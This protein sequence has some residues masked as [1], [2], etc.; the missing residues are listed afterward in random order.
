MLSCCFGHFDWNKENKAYSW[1]E[2]PTLSVRLATF[3]TSASWWSSTGVYMAASLPRSPG[4]FSVFWSFLTVQLFGWCLRVLRF[5]TL[6]I[7]LATDCLS[8]ESQW[9]QVLLLLLLLEFFTSALAD[10]FSLELSD[11]KSPQVSRTHLGCSQQCCHL[12]TLYLS[13]N[14]HVL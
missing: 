11:S 4:L 2:F 5:P 8:Q 6:P 10:G 14:F 3:H 13:A 9:L 7:R 1:I 12:D